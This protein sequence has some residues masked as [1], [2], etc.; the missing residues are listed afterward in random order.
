MSEGESTKPAKPAKPT[1]VERPVEGSEGA[2]PLFLSDVPFPPYRFVPGH[3]PHPYMQEGGY[4]YGE[5]HAPPPHVPTDRWRENHSYLRGLDFFNRGW[6]WEA[7]EEWEA[8]W[9]VCRD[10]DPAQ[11]D[12]L[13][14]LIQFAA[15]ALNLERG[16]DS[17]AKRLVDTACNR[18]G[19]LIEQAPRL[20]GLELAVVRDDARRELVPPRP[21]VDGFYLIAS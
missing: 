10:V 20:A 8:A 21:R 11:H 12:L 4:A 18:L 6:W 17:A 1:P 2:P 9:K 5:S 7:H 14:C 3:A 16:H 13:K 15:A 19:N